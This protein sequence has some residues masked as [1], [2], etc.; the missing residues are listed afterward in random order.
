MPRRRSEDLEYDQEFI[1]KVEHCILSHRGSIKKPAPETIEAKIV[2]SADAMTHFDTFIGLVTIFAKTTN[3][4]KELINELE[5][6]MKRGWEKKLMPEA[7]EIVKEKYGSIMLLIK[8]AKEY[9]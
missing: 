6:K 4:F 3:N 2:C 9:M 8:S 1:E 7:K 5:E